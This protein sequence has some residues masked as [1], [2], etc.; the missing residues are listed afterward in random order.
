MA[1]YILIQLMALKI[2]IHLEMIWRLRRAKEYNVHHQTLK[3]H[4]AIA[5]FRQ[6]LRGEC[7]LGVVFVLCMECD[8]GR[9]H[10]HHHSSEQQEMAFPLDVLPYC[11]TVVRFIT[12]CPTEVG[13]DGWALGFI[14]I[15]KLTLSSEF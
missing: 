2:F 10:A 9:R 11:P 15:R 5:V 8:G 12:C 3:Q 14:E 7:L 1:R 13:Q 4:R 6:L